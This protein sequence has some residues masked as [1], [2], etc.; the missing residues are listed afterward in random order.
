MRRIFA[1]LLLACCMSMP[2]QGQAP[3]IVLIFLDD[4]GY[5][6]F[7]FHGS[8]EAQTPH[9]D[10]LAAQGVRFTQAYVSA[11]VCGP[12]RAGLLT[13][14]Y[15]QR[16]GYYE[17]NVP[18]IM[19]PNGKLVGDDMGLP[20]DQTTIADALGDLGY[21]TMAIG[22]WHLGNAPRYHPLERGFDEFFGFQAGDRP[23]FARE[24]LT[25]SER[26]Q[27]GR[28]EVP[29]PKAYLTDVFADEAAAF[30]ERNAGK[31][32]FFLYL[33][34]NA[35]HAPMQAIEADLA[36]FAHVSDRKR[37]TYLAMLYA[38]DRAVGRVLEA[39]EKSGAASNTLVVFSNDNGGPND[40]N[41]AVNTP[42]AGVK[43]TALEGGI[44]IPTLMRW[45]AGSWRTGSLYDAPIILLDLFPT[46]IAAAGGRPETYPLLDGVNLL[47][48]LQGRL[49]GRPHDILYWLNNQ[50]AAIR[51]GDWKL[52]RFPDRP[53]Q[54]FDLSVDPEE[55]HDRASNQPEL[56]RLLYG[57]LFN[58]ELHNVRPLWMLEVHT[59]GH[60]MQRVNRYQNLEEEDR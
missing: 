42:L 18:G 38:A 9:L 24:N 46:F 10:R 51:A 48:Y 33:A 19:S 4:A 58:W 56:V 5:A 3:N 15:Q 41:A 11:S 49:T 57:M 23:Y 37:R 59:D 13:G 47:P 8:T 54:L 35:P 7:G 26:L 16:F 32:P 6:D 45:P 52:L 2:A 28:E 25:A 36:R 29:E 21:R 20:L 12:S 31:Q 27:R 50:G 55:R 1:L 43:G 44:R 53:A 39:L 34:L 60:A 14:R 22:K 30:I 40:E 17:V